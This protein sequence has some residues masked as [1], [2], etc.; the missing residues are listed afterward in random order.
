[1]RTAKDQY[2]LIKYCYGIASQVGGTIPLKPEDKKQVD[3][4][5]AFFDYD[6][7]DPLCFIGWLR[8]IQEEHYM[9]DIYVLKSA[10]GFNAVCLDIMSLAE[11]RRIGEDI[12]S[13]CDRK[14]FAIN[15]ERGYYT[16][17]FC[18]VDKKL[19]KVLYAEGRSAKSRAH[20]NFLEW[21]FEHKLRII[22]DIWFDEGIW[23]AI[24]RYA[25]AKNG[26]HC[27][28]VRSE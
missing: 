9:S 26:Y 22:D 14:F 1:M 19:Y 2:N 5:V 15:A 4:H 10:H 17:R 18:G 7:E 12:L 25:S 20:K 6:L 13:P 23:P 3:H 24:I 11:I 28:V 8:T 27:E 16:L 21:F